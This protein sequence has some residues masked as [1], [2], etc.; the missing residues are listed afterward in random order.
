LQWIADQN[1]WTDI[2]CVS[3][4]HLDGISGESGGLGEHGREERKVIAEYA[5]H[6]LVPFKRETHG[7]LTLRGPK[8]SA[9]ELKE[10]P[11]NRLKMNKETA[12]F[13]LRNPHDKDS[14]WQRA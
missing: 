5:V 4:I 1:I 14:V 6:G 2:L 10:K 8:F 13:V 9:W 3:G 11:N 7:V 12:L